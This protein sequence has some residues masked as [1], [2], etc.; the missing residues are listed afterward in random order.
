MFTGAETDFGGIDGD[1]RPAITTRMTGDGVIFSD[2]NE[3][4]IL[5][6]DSGKPPGSAS[7][8]ER[9][10][11]YPTEITRIGGER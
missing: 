10:E 11:F 9:P 8:I 4:D 6:I 2:G 5:G 1:R 7:R 3:V